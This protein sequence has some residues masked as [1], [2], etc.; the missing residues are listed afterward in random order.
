MAVDT[1]LAWELKVELEAFASRTRQVFSKA[2]VPLEAFMVFADTQLS[3]LV[4]H[5]DFE[6]D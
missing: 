3:P 6:P 4:W 2:A 1:L 5:L